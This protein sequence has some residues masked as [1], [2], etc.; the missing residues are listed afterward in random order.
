MIRS[1]KC[2]NR[3]KSSFFSKIKKTVNCNNMF[4]NNQKFIL[5]KNEVIVELFAHL[6]I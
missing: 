5:R 6:T 1:R 4:G 2:D 3:Q